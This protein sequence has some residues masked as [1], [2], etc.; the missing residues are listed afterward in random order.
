MCTRKLVW[1]V[2]AYWVIMDMPSAAIDYLPSLGN[3]SSLAL[4]SL[5]LLGRM[6]CKVLIN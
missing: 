4:A 1:G 6:L 3:L 5:R 2:N